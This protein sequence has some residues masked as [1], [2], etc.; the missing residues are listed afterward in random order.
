MS[1]RA[2][3]NSSERDGSTRKRVSSTVD[4]EVPLR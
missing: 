3:S 1:V 4:I 2:A